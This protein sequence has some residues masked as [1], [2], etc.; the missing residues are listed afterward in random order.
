MEMLFVL[1]EKRWYSTKWLIV[2]SVKAVVSLCKLIISLCQHFSTNRLDRVPCN[3]LVP[4]H[5]YHNDKHLNTVIPLNFLA[6]RRVMVVRKLVCQLL[7]VYSVSIWSNQQKDHYPNG[8]FNPVDSHHI[9]HEQ[10][11]YLRVLFNLFQWYPI[12]WIGLKHS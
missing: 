7:V 1:L 6:H 2:C 4:F 9:T 11:K 8:P 10:N 12:F 5:Q 3:N